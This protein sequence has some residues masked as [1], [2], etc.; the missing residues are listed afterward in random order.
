MERRETASAF[1]MQRAYLYLLDRRGQQWT[2][3][4]DLTATV[5]ERGV[6]NKGYTI[7]RAWPDEKGA[8]EVRNANP[9][10]ALLDIFSSPKYVMPT[11]RCLLNE[12]GAIVGTGLDEIIRHVPTLSGKINEA[13][14]RTLSKIVSLGRELVEKEKDVTSASP[15]FASAKEVEDLRTYLLQYSYNMSQLL[16]QILHQESHCGTFVQLGGLDALLELLET[17][18]ALL[19]EVGEHLLLLGG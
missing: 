7:T 6:L 19:F 12:M 3:R 4:H 16:E 9:F 8:V 10:P 13:I 18:L 11:S 15:S 17:L 5:R 1:E 2:D 14:V